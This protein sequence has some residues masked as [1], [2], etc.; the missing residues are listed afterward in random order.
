MNSPAVYDGGHSHSHSRRRRRRQIYGDSPG[1]VA[2]GCVNI[3]LSVT[4]AI[5]RILKCDQVRHSVYK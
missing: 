4:D 1:N 5:K 2:R 3:Q